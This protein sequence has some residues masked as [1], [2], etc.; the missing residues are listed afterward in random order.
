MFDSNSIVNSSQCVEFTIVNDNIIEANETFS[1]QLRDVSSVTF[2]ESVTT[3]MI[4]DDDCKPILYVPYS[5]NS[6]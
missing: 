2:S 1:V 6:V 3:I 5:I 4:I